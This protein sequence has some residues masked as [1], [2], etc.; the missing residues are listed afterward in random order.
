MILNVTPLFPVATSMCPSTSA[1]VLYQTAG[2]LLLPGGLPHAVRGSV[3]GNTSQ[4]PGG[5]PHAVRGSVAGNTSQLPGGL[6]HAVRGSVAGNTSRNCQVDSP[7]L[8]EALLRGIPR[9]HCDKLAFNSSSKVNM[10]P[11]YAHS[12][13]VWF[14]CF[15]RKK[16]ETAI[17][18]GCPNG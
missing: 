2:W 14:P 6:P 12:S 4:L 9:N 11:C 7:M 1:R 10:C 8:S 18:G 3:A 5:L 16:N 13:V 15:W 17:A